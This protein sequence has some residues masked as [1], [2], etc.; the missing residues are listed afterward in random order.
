MYGPKFPG[1]V[2]ELDDENVYRLDPATKALSVVATLGKPNGIAFSPDE[3]WLYLTDSRQSHI[4]RFPVKGETLGK[5]DVFVDLKFK[6]LDGLAFDPAG[7]LWCGTR[8]GAYVFS[9]QAQLLG[10]VTFED[11][12]SSFAFKKLDDGQVYLGLTTRT[13]AYVAKLNQER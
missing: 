1:Q 4:L 10:T 2:R 7:N 8:Q 3:K 13:A 6:G 12:V 9:P 11:R 5:P